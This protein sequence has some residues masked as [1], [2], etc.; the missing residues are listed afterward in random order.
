L[1]LD[2]IIPCLNERQN[3]ES[4]LPFLQS[5]ASKKDIN[6]LVIDASTS[7]DDTEIVCRK[8]NVRYHRSAATQ[9]SLQMNFGV[10]KCNGDVLLFL[11]ADVTPPI[12][13]YDL[14]CDAVAQGNESGCFAYKFDSTK[15]ML[16]I[17]SYFTQFEG[18]IT[19][20]GDQGQ[21][22]TRECFNTLGG[23]CPDHVIMEDF[24]LYKKIKKYNI[25]HKVIKDKAIVSARKY[26]NNSW[27]RVNLINLIALL[28][29]RADRNPV[30]I[31]TFYKKWLRT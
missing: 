13:F 22:I 17:N 18:L 27:L 31:K 23:F 21:Y 5:S 25:S 7:S 30:S 15:I 8:N 4:L 20:G 26:D 28:Q 12:K 29:Y 6:I 14:I 1:K 3:L 19:G 10:K 9:R 2:I 24:D 11:H 16:R